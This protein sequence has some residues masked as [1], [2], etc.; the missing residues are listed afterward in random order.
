M[1]DAVSILAALA[2]EGR[3]DL[4]R[5]L[6]VAGPKG[7]VVSEL[8]DLANAG[9]TTVSARLSVLE[10]AGLITNQR[11]GRSIRYFADFGAASSVLAFLMK[12]CCQG[13]PDIL[14]PLADLTTVT[15]CCAPLDTQTSTREPS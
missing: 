13:H 6:V 5:H 9:M 3:L 1:K 15:D 8:T 12:D 2:H 4:F 11:E 10:H 7:L 14:G